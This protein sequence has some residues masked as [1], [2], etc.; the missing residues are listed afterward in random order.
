MRPFPCLRLFVV[1]LALALPG[2]GSLRAQSP[3]PLVGMAAQGDAAQMLDK[4]VLRDDSL[5]QVLALLEMLTGRLVIRPQALPTPM[6][7]FNSQGPISRQDAVIALESLLSINGIAVAPLGERFIKIVPVGNVRTEAPELIIGSLRDRPPSGRVVGKLFRLEHLDTTTFQ[8]QVQPFLSPGFGTVVP[9]QNTNTLL[10]IDTISNLQRLEYVLGEVDRP[11][12]LVTKFYTLRYAQASQVAEKIR[13]L[14]DATRSAFNPQAGARPGGGGGPAVAPE[15]G[16]AGGVTQALLAGSASI[17]FDER[18]NQI[19]LVAEPTSVAFYDNLIEKLDV[20][21]DPSTQIA[22]ISIQHATATEVA[23]LLA[24]F[25]SGSTQAAQQASGAGQRGARPAVTFRE[26]FAPARTQLP[27]PGAEGAPPPPQ[28]A[29]TAAATA[30][31]ERSSQFSPFMTIVADDRSNSI[32]ASGTLD[33]LV[34]VRELIRQIDIVLP[35]VRVE[36]LV[37]EVQLNNSVQRGIDGFDLRIEGDR[38]VGF[39]GTASGITVGGGTIDRT[40]PGNPLSMDLVVRA[41]NRRANVNILSA[42]TVVTTHNKEATIVVAQARPI[43]TATQTSLDAQVGLRTNFTFQDIG[44]NLRVKPL[45]GNEGTIQL[46]IDQ[47]A[48]DVVDNVTIDGNE[49]PII[50]RRQAVSFISVT[51]GEIVVLGGLRSRS[52]N[53]TQARFPIVG[54]LPIIGGLFGKTTR[55]RNV[56]ELLVFIRP[57]LLLTPAVANRTAEELIRNS[58]LPEETKARLLGTLEEGPAE[59]VGPPVGRG[60][61]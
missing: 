39:A 17:N 11:R 16:D 8:T 57:T 34:L 15:G 33:D 1:L 12:N 32:V 44:L 54:E 41:V 28:P 49:Q 52:L 50:G 7:T 22:V 30:A 13:S 2:V 60:G 48:D 26:T 46:E 51:D 19:I 37:A 21:A 27:L 24:Q 35:Q 59:A 4:L 31:A 10:V 58:R 18:T 42:P 9:F 40:L 20:Q 47:S 23:S 6:F 45:I 53:T 56:T 38:V 61:R 5:S 25:I 29:P 3:E 43:V 55:D 14:I 36:V